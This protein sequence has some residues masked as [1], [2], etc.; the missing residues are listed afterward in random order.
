MNRLSRLV[1]EARW[2]W[3]LN[4]LLWWCSEHKCYH[5]GS[6]SLRRWR[7]AHAGH[8]AHA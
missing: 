4:P 3:V 1:L 6:Y 8:L 7:R 5:V 2:G